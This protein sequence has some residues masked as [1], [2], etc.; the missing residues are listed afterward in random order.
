MIAQFGIIETLLNSF[1]RHKLQLAATT[2]ISIQQA[3]IINYIGVPK[4]SRFTCLQRSQ[5]KSLKTN[6]PWLEIGFP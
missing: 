1:L 4:T 6:E 2:Y 3:V 5:P